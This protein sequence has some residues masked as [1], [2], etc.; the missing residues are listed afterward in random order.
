MKKIFLLSLIAVTHFI[1][2]YSQTPIIKEFSTNSVEEFLNDY[3]SYSSSHSNPVCKTEAT[4]FSASFGE[5]SS[6]ERTAFMKLANDM[7]TLKGKP[8]P[9]FLQLNKTINKVVASDDKKHLHQHILAINWV[10]NN[11]TGNILKKVEDYLNFTENFATQGNLY[12]SSTRNSRLLNFDYTYKIDTV[13]PIITF[14]KNNI[15]HF[16]KGDTI[17]L[18]NISGDFFPLSSIVKASYAETDFKKLGYNPQDVNLKL[19]NF[20]WDFSKVD[21]EVDSSI[22]SFKPYL[23]KLV[24]GKYIDKLLV[25]RPKSNMSFPQFISTNREAF[26][27]FSPE[28]SFD[29]SLQII[30]DRLYIGAPKNQL[31]SSVKVSSSHNAYVRAVAPRFMIRDFNEII[32][33]QASVAMYIDNDSITHPLSEFKY[34]INKR[35]ISITKTD[36]ASGK[37]PFA[38]TFHQMNI[39]TDKIVWN[40]DSSNLFLRP[41]SPL[42]QKPAVIESFDYYEK[43]AE[44]KYQNMG[45]TNPLVILD[46]MT[47]SYGVPN[48]VIPAADLA[49]SMGGLSLNV[50]S[51]ENLLYRLTEDGFIVYNSL[52]QTIRILDKTNLYIDASKKETD[53]DNMRFFSKNAKDNGKLSITEKSIDFKGIEELSISES[54]GVYAFPKKSSLSIEEDRSMNFDGDVQ[55]G[56]VLFIGEDIFFDYKGFKV[57]FNKLDS[58]IIFIPSNKPDASGNTPDIALRTVISDISGE[59]YVDEPGNRSSRNNYEEYPYFISKDTA[60]IYYEKASHQNRKYEKDKFKFGI[61]PFKFDNLDEFKYKEINFPGTLKAPEIIEPIRA[62]LIVMSDMSLG[63]EKEIAKPGAKMYNQNAFF[64]QKLRLN[65]DGLTGEGELNF[66]DATMSSPTFYFFPDSV[67]A[68]LNDFK[69]TKNIKANIPQS[70][71]DS[72]YLYWTPS[73]DSLIVSRLGNAFEMYDKKGLYS[74]DL[75]FQKKNV[76]NGIGKFEWT[77]GELLSSLYNFKADALDA[78][79][80]VLE[81]KT[82]DTS[83][84]AIMV[85]NAEVNLDFAKN[86]TSVNV[87]NDSVLTEL[88]ITLLVTNASNYNWDML[89]EKVTFIKQ[90]NESQ[91]FL[92]VNPKF[93]S[94]KFE[95]NEATYS[96]KENNLF[97]KGITALYVADSKVIPSEGKLMIEAGGEIGVMENATIIFNAEKEFHKIDKASVNI[98]SSKIFEGKGQ[99]EYK[100]S[101]GNTKNI[102]IEEIGVNIDTIIDSKGKKGVQE[103]YEYTTYGVGK[104]YEEENFKFEDI[105]FYKGDVLLSSK[106]QDID[107]EG[108]A[109]LDIQS[110]EYVDWF[111]LDQQIDPKNLQIK[112][113]NLENDRKQPILSGLMVNPNYQTLYPAIMRAKETSQDVAIFEATGIMKPGKVKDTYLF[114]EEDTLQDKDLYSSKMIYNDALQTIEA[115]GKMNLVGALRMVKVEAYGDLNYKS[116]YNKTDIAATIGIDFMLEPTIW[117]KLASDIEKNNE[118]T[119]SLSYKRNNTIK[120]AMYNWIADKKIAGEVVQ[121]MDMDNYLKLPDVFPFKFVLTEVLLQWDG[122][123][124]TFKGTDKVGLVALNNK[125]IEQKVKCDIEIGYRSGANEMK[126]LL[127]TTSGV[128]YFFHLRN[129]NVGILSSDES[130]N[131]T[132]RNSLKNSIVTKT[133]G[134]I[135]DAV[136]GN[137]SAKANFDYA[138]Q[139]FKERLKEQSNEEKK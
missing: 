39:Y 8:F 56:K 126:I 85:S 131:E 53:Y 1:Y 80:A 4:L 118:T 71:I 41:I 5:F 15:I 11:S 63:F 106:S 101:F 52:D 58:M 48:L 112:L 21:L 76:L 82:S 35:E 13:G 44:L 75:I 18:K 89:G 105:I 125:M 91:Y 123:D 90:P 24:S 49:A 59:L 78:Q 50:K 57:D 30:G 93:D 135:Y 6:T 68:V 70:S 99:L 132:M 122:I 110:A 47:K 103:R 32:S 136:V 127:T 120:Q 73:K 69:T 17:D 65:N 28:V 43:G 34:L 96:L 137:R 128:W 64:S 38:S 27:K 95:A 97:A 79:N 33:D 102:N 31:I 133:D 40:I 138:M 55:A 114:G 51:I 42:S 12:S 20:N 109:K 88:P 54:K 37:A 7:L 100:N 16:T 22:T 66:E 26:T 121:S 74:G 124:G 86:M 84:N 45:G 108:Y 87:I 62:S 116:Q 117:A 10:A 72:A 9:N 61:D 111:K 113:A 139:D 23:D 107:F 14:S 92:S 29:G 81:I 36:K 115:T 3:I 46:Q 19:F 119:L 67:F 83:V 94:L 25:I 134:T 60:Y 104:I 77:R 129:G 2:G 98:Q 130:M